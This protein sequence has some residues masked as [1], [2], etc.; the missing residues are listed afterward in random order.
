MNAGRTSSGLRLVSISAL[1]FAFLG[2]AF[3][4]WLPLGMVFSLTGLLFGFADWMMARR[5]SLDFRLSIIAVVL[6]IVALSL[7]VVIAVLGLQKVT[8]GSLW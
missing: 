3:C 5:R 8:F 6:S 1:I 4:W 2:G 7:D